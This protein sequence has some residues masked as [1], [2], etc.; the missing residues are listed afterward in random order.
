[1]LTGEEGRIDDRRLRNLDRYVLLK[2]K[3]GGT[4][5]AVRPMPSLEEARKELAHLNG[6]SVRWHILDLQENK[7]VC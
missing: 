4:P 2:Y 6:E 1:M 5:E 7:E 3:P